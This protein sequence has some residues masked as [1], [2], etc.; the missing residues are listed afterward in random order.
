MSER[1]AKHLVVSGRVQGVGF[2]PFIYRLALTHGLVG[3]VKND[4]GSVI[5]HIEGDAAE[6]QSFI[7]DLVVKGPPLAQPFLQTEKS[8]T[9]EDCD[10]F[11]IL[12]SSSSEKSQIHIPPD[13][14]ICDDCL[15]EMEDEQERRH[16]YPFINCTQ[17]G[18]RYTI[19]EAMPY[20]RP[21]TSLKDFPLCD[22]CRSE[23]ENPLD[24][25]FH[26]Q[27]LACPVCGPSLS[28]CRSED[29]PNLEQTIDE[30]LELAISSL[31]KGEIV[32]I[33]GV[34]GY[35]LM[36]DA[37]NTSAIR[38]LRQRKQRPDKPFAV[39]YPQR[40]ADGLEVVRTATSPGPVEA[41]V[42]L[43]PVRPIVMVR[44]KSDSSLSPAIAPG[45]GE[46][47]IFLPYSPLHH[48]ILKKFGGPLIATS[49][50]VSGEPVLADE[51]EAAH[52]LSGIADCFLHHNRPIV[53][54]AD[55][56]VICVIANKPRAIRLG[57]GT[58]PLELR[59]PTHLDHP[60]FA[61]G[62]HMKVT[63]ALAFEDRVIISPHIGDLDS[64]RAMDVF[65][66]VASDLQQLYDVSAT[67]IIC[68]LHPNYASSRWACQQSLPIVHVQHHRAHASA[69]AGEVP[70]I[71]KWLTFTW[72]GVG[73][74]DDGSLWGGEAFF[75]SPGNWQRMA[76]FRPFY[77]PGGTRAGIEPWRSASALMWASGEDFKPAGLDVSNARLAYDKRLNSPA[78]SAIGRLFDAAAALV[79]G[80]QTASFEGQGPM[81]LEAIAEP[82]GTPVA[83][84]LKADETGLLRTDW[85][86]LLAMLKDQSRLPAARA[87]DFHESLAKA[88][89]DQVELISRTQ[90]FEAVGLTGGVFQNRLLA[91]LVMDR[92]DKMGIATYLPERI[93][94][95]DG[96]LCYGQV[97]ETLFT[98]TQL[99][100]KQHD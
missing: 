12:S 26:A 88:L 94:A 51:G 99:T 75:G 3:W 25:R 40:G 36:V 24:R 16:N 44:K 7:E 29:R 10:G 91:E 38:R 53:R 81:Q 92:L 60:V 69:L 56:P 63:I 83:L 80:I 78:T 52:R 85:Q 42:L 41:K 57:R 47:G 22:D 14:F 61:V 66:K 98:P 33:K 58:A 50:N 87:A 43:D 31:R 5:I 6:A 13:L 34:G 49:G 68:D 30:V 70:D 86:P 32:A 28:Y 93:P 67:E 9:L 8:A 62:G 82:S 45:L 64:P 96:G 2:R 59:L 55:D 15:D 35:H 90:E 84:S 39:M 18:P 21:N 65:A 20:D 46:L 73:Y 72:D 17:C 79:L 48:L 76:S 4:S 77:P 37:K 27:P 23:Y 95:N 71:K 100:G 97:I 11:K 54:P 1:S 89:V 74:G 19:I